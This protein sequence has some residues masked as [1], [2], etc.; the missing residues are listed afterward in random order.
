MRHW[1]GDQF[2]NSVHQSESVSF[3]SL[4]S[5]VAFMVY[6]RGKL[7]LEDPSLWPLETSRRLREN[8]PTL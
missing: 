4:V 1:L 5:F 8:L 6:D 3:V 2:D 7:D